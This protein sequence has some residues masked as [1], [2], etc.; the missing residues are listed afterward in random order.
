MAGQIRG[1]GHYIGNILMWPPHT[2]LRWLMASWCWW[3][4]TGPSR[5]CMVWKSPISRARSSGW[6]TPCSSS[7]AC[8]AVSTKRSI[9]T[10]SI[11]NLLE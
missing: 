2:A 8:H 3:K 11:S 4:N 6:L 10:G 1:Q 5:I 9:F 7:F